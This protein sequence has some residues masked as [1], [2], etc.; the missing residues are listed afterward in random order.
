MPIYR[1]AQVNI[2]IEP[3]YED[4]AR[5]LLP[6]LTD[7][8]DCALDASATHDEV[9]RYIAAQ[10]LRCPPA[11]AEG[12]IVY[13]K[14]CRE[15]LSR[16]DGFFFHSSCFSFDGAG[17]LFTAR[18]GTGKSTHTRLWRERFGERVRMINDDKPIIRRIDGT[19]YVCGTPWMGKSDIGQNLTA[20]V[21]AVVVLTRD[22]TDHAE[23][24]SP[25][26][27]FRELMEATLLPRERTD[28]ARLLELYDGL[29]AQAKLIRLGC[30]VSQNAVDAAYRAIFDDRKGEKP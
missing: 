2:K 14:I 8:E 23:E 17:V 19:F 28:M 6:Y 7:G 21:R 4:T 22:D 10:N 9:G 5:R 30:T 25:S 16:F 26:A 29:F 15:M 27:V 1:I 12:S 11:L 24:V 3:L 20:P 13:T 18:S